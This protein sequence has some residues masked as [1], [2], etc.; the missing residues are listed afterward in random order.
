MLKCT[1]IS[2]ILKCSPPRR[3]GAGGGGSTPVVWDT[4]TQPSPERGRALGFVSCQRDLLREDFE[5]TF[6][7]SQN[8]VVPEADYAV[9]M[10]FDKS[11]SL[12]VGSVLGMLSAIQLDREPQ[13]ATGKIG[14]ETADR[15]LSRK[16]HTHLPSTQMRPQVPFRIGRIP[17]QP[18]RNRRQALSRHTSDTP[19]QPSPDRGRAFVA[20]AG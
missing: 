20:I 8:F 1:D 16:L 5:D 15:K 12:S 14:D 13:A 2:S 10:G 3:G 19:T 4:P 6:D 9:A 11:G 7:V 18:L 17:A